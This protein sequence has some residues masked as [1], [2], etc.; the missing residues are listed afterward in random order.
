LLKNKKIERQRAEVKKV[1][2]MGGGFKVY[3]KRF[4]FILL[5]S[6]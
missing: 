4:I 6:K 2:E 3:A 1:S 5:L